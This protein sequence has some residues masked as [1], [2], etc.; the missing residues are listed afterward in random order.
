ML[1]FSLGNA[2]QR[3]VSLAKIDRLA[4]HSS[5]ARHRNQPARL[6]YSRR[7]GK[8]ILISY[9]HSR[10]N[11]TKIDSD[12]NRKVSAFSTSSTFHVNVYYPQ[13]RY[14]KKRSE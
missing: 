9:E 13:R 6:R 11:R 7:T 3:K 14:E 4:K 12:D 2:R 10:H 8:R 1:E 5:D